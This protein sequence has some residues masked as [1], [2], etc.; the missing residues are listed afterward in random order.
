MTYLVR[1]EALDKHIKPFSKKHESERTSVPGLLYTGSYRPGIKSSYFVHYTCFISIDEKLEYKCIWYEVSAEAVYLEKVI[2]Q[3]FPNTI[4]LK[5]SMIFRF[6]EMCKIASS[7]RTS[8]HMEQQ[9]W[10]LVEM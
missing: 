9:T 1:D 7:I 2:I 5:D 8:K 4:L 6:M 3:K 10:Y